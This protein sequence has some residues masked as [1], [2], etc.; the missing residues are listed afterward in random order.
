MTLHNTLTR[1]K[2]QLLKD[3]DN[4]DALLMRLTNTDQ[5]A[6][7]IKTRD[8]IEFRLASIRNY[9]SWLK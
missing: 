5:I 1:T 7:A 8:Q 3:R 9:L 4:Y 6:K 2:A